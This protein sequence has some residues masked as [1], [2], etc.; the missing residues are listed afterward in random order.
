MA[1]KKLNTY[2]T[3]LEVFQEAI[4]KAYERGEDIQ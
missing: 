4:K 3:V 1:K 2:F